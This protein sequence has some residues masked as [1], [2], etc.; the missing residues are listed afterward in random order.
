MPPPRTPPTCSRITPS[1]SCG[2][3]RTTGR[4]SSTSRR[5][6][7]TR[8]GRRRSGTPARSRTS[9]IP[10]SPSVDERNV[11]DK[12]AWVQRLRPV[13]AVERAGCSRIGGTRRRRSSAWTMPSSGSSSQLRASGELDHTVILFLTDNGYSFGEHRIRG[14][15]LP[16]RGVHPDAVRGARARGARRTT[17]PD[18]S[19]T[20]TSPP[21]SRIWRASCPGSRGRAE[22]RARAARRH[23]GD[24]PAGVF[25]EWAGDRE[26]PAWQGVR[27]I[28][29]AYIEDADGTVELYDLT[30]AIGR[31]DPYEL[32]SRAADPRY[33]A[34]RATARRDAARVP[35]PFSGPTIDSPIVQQPPDPIIRPA[36]GRRRRPTRTADPPTPGD[37]RA[38]AR[39]RGLP[40]LA[41]LALRRRWNDVGGPEPEPELGTRER[42]R[43]RR[44]RRRRGPR[45]PDQ[46]RHLH[47]QGE[48]DLQ[49]LLR[50]V[51]PRRRGNVRRVGRSTC[52]ERR[53]HA[54]AGLQA[55]DGP[56][57]PAARHHA[58]VLVGSVLDQRRRDERLQHHRLGRGHDGV[59]PTSTGP[60]I[61]NYWAYADRFVLADHFFTSMYGPTFP[62]HLYTVAAQSRR[63]RRQQEHRRPPGELLRRSHRVH[64]AL[65]RRPHRRAEE[66]DH[67]VRGAT[68]RTTS[69]T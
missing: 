54:R 42:Q 37:L 9:P 29:F 46:A 13:D 39:C 63:H 34:T 32:R 12:P 38:G 51:R 19:P 69:R 23:R 52:T 5:A 31:A 30:G 4:S 11:S 26:I 7:R 55:D 67:D 28:D 43:S 50:D 1:T 14:Q 27:T 58:R 44:A 6:R 57:H 33:R 17:S 35:H 68:T 53:L 41:V 65:P 2:P 16:V 40:R 47:G 15:A 62:E 22:L 18:S 49:Q 61:P 48:P 59:R 3:R 21:R 45:Q 20:W 60:S 8:R 36:S 64:A 25:L 24:A 10:V 56:R 66:E